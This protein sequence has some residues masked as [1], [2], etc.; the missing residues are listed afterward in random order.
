V[1]Q[2]VEMTLNVSQP[3]WQVEGDSAD[4]YE[5]YLASA[6][7]P[8]AA[9]LVELAGVGSGDRVLDAA[10]GT[11]IVARHAAARTGPTGRVVGVDINEDMLRVAAS[12][13]AAVR[14][15]IEWRHGDVATL[16][17]ADGTFDV[18]CCE[19]ALQFFPDPVR[20][21]AEMHRVLGAGG[22]V[23]LSVCRAI[24]YAPT[25][26][27]LADA[28]ER[29]VGSEAGAIMR[30]P[31]AGWDAQQVHALLAA[32]GFTGAR[33]L[34]DVCG[35]RYPSCEEFVRRE[36]SSSPLADSVRALPRERRDALVRDVGE[37]IA[38]HLDDNGV[39]CPLEVYVVV[40]RR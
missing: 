40:A 18:A 2:E 25:Y 27:A 10:C 24:R 8:W 35:L 3:G 5:R 32:A 17:F 37:A 13:A 31:F 14:P 23:A 30:S 28:L 9:Q 33:V 11:G 29:H 12:A 15:P 36:A 7:S 38:D 22:R 34:I 26:V 16:P 6:F 4:A 39:L 1:N 19:Q 20:A 21:L